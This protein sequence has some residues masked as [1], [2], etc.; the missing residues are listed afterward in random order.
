MSA[1]CAISRPA[2]RAAAGPGRP[3]EEQAGQRRLLEQVTAGD[4]SI[5]AAHEE[6]R[7][8]LDALPLVRP[9]QRRGERRADLGGEGARHLVQLGGG[10]LEE[11]LG[12]GQELLQGGARGQRQVEEDAGHP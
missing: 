10:A 1:A 9:Q 2:P 4:S 5:E 3:P 8:G 11:R 12:E 7:V 6:D